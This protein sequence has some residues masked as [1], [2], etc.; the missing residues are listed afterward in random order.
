M[1]TNRGRLHVA[2][3]KAINAQGRLHQMPLTHLEPSR[4]LIKV[5]PSCAFTSTHVD[6]NTRSASAK[7]AG[8][9][10]RTDVARGLFMP[11]GTAS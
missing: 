6:P 9:M 1:I 10:T 11:L 3:L 2:N 4:P 5:L 7:T 8:S